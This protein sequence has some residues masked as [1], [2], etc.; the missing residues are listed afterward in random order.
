MSTLDKALND[1]NLPELVRCLRCVAEN[2]DQRYGMCDRYN[3]QT[4]ESCPL[5]TGLNTSEFTRYEEQ[6]DR[7]LS[8]AAKAMQSLLCR[9]D[10]PA[11]DRELFTAMKAGLNCLT[12]ESMRNPMPDYEFEA[13]GKK[14][15]I[16]YDHARRALEACCDHFM[17]H[18]GFL[19]VIE[20]ETALAMLMAAG[21][22]KRA[23]IPNAA[24]FT[25]RL[26]KTGEEYTITFRTAEELLGRVGETI[27]QDTSGVFE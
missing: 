7:V 2:I 1:H 9:I 27:L 20:K 25:F 21:S 18:D 24:Y 6:A 23:S 16:S 19:P 12:L 15:S 3:D 14:L 26:D 5:N 11:M 22:I 8:M 17:D 4:C 13:N 10:L